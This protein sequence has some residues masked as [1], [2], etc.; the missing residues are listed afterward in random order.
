M[1]KKIFAVLI[2]FLFI[3][4]AFYAGYETGAHNENS[5]VSPS[6]APV[7][8]LYS[9]WVIAKAPPI[10]VIH[11]GGQ[12]IKMYRGAY[13]WSQVSANN[14]NEVFEVLAD[15]VSY[16]PMMQAIAVPAG[17]LMQSTPPARIKKF[18]IINMTEGFTGDPYSSN[19]PDTKGVYTYRID[20][21]WL[22]D[23]GEANYFFSL[24]VE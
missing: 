22:L 10:P 14:S 20:C 5:V 11:V 4:G 6:P 17:A 24:R 13:S 1:R 19:V 3:A 15:G 21:E 7:P 9:Q 12:N 2:S 23:Q 8:S 16:P 18:N